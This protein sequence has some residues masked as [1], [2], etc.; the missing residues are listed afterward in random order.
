M[1]FICAS[2]KDYAREKAYAF[3]GIVR[4]NFYKY[5]LENFVR[6]NNLDNSSS[7]NVKE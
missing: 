2:D 5:K 1:L 7:S 4:D 6:S 3:L